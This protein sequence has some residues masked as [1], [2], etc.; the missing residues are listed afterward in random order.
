M[1][2]LYDAK[3]PICGCVNKD[4]DL[5]ETEGWMECERCKEIVRFPQFQKSIKI[6]VYDMAHIPMDRMIAGGRL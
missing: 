1:M 6:P 5:R 3:C 2:S 4:V